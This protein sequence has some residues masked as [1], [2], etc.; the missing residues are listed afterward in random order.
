M[1]SVMLDIAGDT[2]LFVPIAEAGTIGFARAEFTIWLLRLNERDYLGVARR[3]AFESYRARM[4]EY[5]TVRD[6]GGTEAELR[7]M[8][9][10]LQR[11]QHPTVWHEMKRQHHLVPELRTMFSRVPEALH[12]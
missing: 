2:F 4:R 6:A 12:W 3:E 7:R 10:A 9:S 8:Q 1:D 5:G 11:V